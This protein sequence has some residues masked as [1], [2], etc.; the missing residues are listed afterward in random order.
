GVD[1]HHLTQEL[2]RLAARP[3]EGV[4]SDDRPEAA[5][6]TDT[7]DL[8]EDGGRL[9]RLAAGEDDDSAPGEGALH[10]VTD[11]LGERADG[12]LLL[13]VDLLRGRL[14]EVRGRRLHLHDVRAELA[15]DLRRVGDD[16]DRGLPLLRDPRAARI[17]PD[18]DGQALPLRL[19]GEAA[20]LVEHLVP[21]RRGGV[22][23]EAD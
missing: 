11:A 5:A 18:D 6:V 14:L 3:L 2:D 21:R 16:V 13:L 17:G 1:V 15:G 12:D 7:A 10:D 23:R 20:D 9:L 8:V 4:P 19:L 22:D